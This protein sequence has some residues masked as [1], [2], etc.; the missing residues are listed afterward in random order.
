[1]KE[2][3]SI[4]EQQ[5]FAPQGGKPGYLIN[6]GKP[7]ERWVGIDVKGSNPAVL[8]R[9]LDAYA[10][11]RGAAQLKADAEKIRTSS[12]PPAAQPP[13]STQP[14]AK[15][16][17]A[18][19]VAPKPAPVPFGKTMP[20]PASAALDKYKINKDWAA[21]NPRLAQAQVKRAEQRASGKSAFDPE[22]RK[23]TINPILYKP[24]ALKAEETMTKDSYDLVLEY[25]L[26]NGHADTI[27]EA[28]YVMMQMSAEHIQDIVEDVYT[29]PIRQEKPQPKVE[30]IE[31][32]P[33]SET[34]PTVPSPGSAEG[35]TGLPPGQVPPN[36]KKYASGG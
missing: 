16:P 5:V 24:G 30:K 13:A 20:A 4:N 1:M 3:F 12:P 10:R 17:A 23:S 11:L 6:K 34:K 21:A 32:K 33:R 7:N 18:T 35:G 8:Q 29:G 14:P 26:S 36:V 28:H 2:D 27:L 31:K 15:P 22:F 9:Q 25:L 19:P